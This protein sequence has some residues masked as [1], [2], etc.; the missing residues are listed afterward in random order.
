MG[1]SKKFSDR[2][3][4]KKDI[5]EKSARLFN[6]KG[7]LSTSIKD[8][9]EVT[10]LSKGSIYGNFS[11]KEEVALEVFRYNFRYLFSGIDKLVSEA[12][13]AKGQLMA[14]VLFYRNNH[15]L[16]NEMGGC[17]LLNVSVDVDDTNPALK[18]K[19]IKY[20]KT[21]EKS[22]THSIK[23]GQLA[24]EW[25]QDV[26]PKVFFSRLAGLIQ[27]GVFLAKTTGVNDYLFHNLDLL[28]EY[29]L[30]ICK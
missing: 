26:D 1:R 24:G 22:V 15:H 21:W 18:A 4:T 12:P 10:G 3:Q 19:S 25:N 11:N 28:E 17:P 16:V 20:I 5:I 9:E 13:D 29:I 30:S 7:Y 27:G 23:Q 14:Y 2:E 8:I 6:E